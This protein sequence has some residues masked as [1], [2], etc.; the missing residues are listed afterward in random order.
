[1]R[2][3]FDAVPLGVFRASRSG[4]LLA[5]NQALADLL[6]YP[7]VA[8]LLQVPV[9]DLYTDTEARE[10]L[11]ARLDRP[12]ASARLET[13]FR[14]RDGSALWAE[15]WARCI[16]TDPEPVYAGVLSDTT[17]R[18]HM[19]DALRESEALFRRVFEQLPVG[20]ALV[21]MSGHFDRANA[22]WIK[23]IGYSETELRE[24]TFLD[25]THPDDK[26][27]SSAAVRRLYDGE[28]D[29]IEMEKRYVRKDGEIVWGYVS[30]RPIRDAAGQPLWTM[31]VII[32]ITG[33]RALEEQFR[34]AQKMEAIGRLAGGVAHDFNN[35]LT[36]I[37]GYSELL[38]EQIGPDKPM[39]RDL[40]QIYQGALRAAALTR[41][42]LAFSRKQ[43]LRPESV[44]LNQILSRFQ[45]LARP[46]LGEDVQLQLELDPSVGSICADVTQLEQV[47]MN[48]LVNS[49]DAMPSGG[50]IIIRTARY[51]VST[52]PPAR[53]GPMKPGEYVELSVQD[54]G[55]GM[56]EDTKRHV[57]E[58]FFTTKE[59]GKGTGLGL[60]TV[61]G[62]IEQM[63]GYI[64]VE[65]A[66]GRGTTFRICFPPS[67]PATRVA[68][69]PAVA[70][71]PV[72]SE[73]ILVVEDDPDARLFTTAALRRYGYRVTEAASADEALRQLEGQERWPD[74]VLTDIV[75]PGRNG[76]DLAAALLAERPGTR[77]LLTTGYLDN[78]VN[79]PA[80]D[81]IPILEKPF[82]ATTL[83]RRVRE[84]LERA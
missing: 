36:A 77:I 74:L 55:I 44:E 52:R 27:A 79:A 47:L 45:G 3:I 62:I 70:G 5:A 12:G 73:R 23:M 8:T 34:H 30:V 83:L 1:M 53:Q 75:M 26:A 2:E 28:T 20:T 81:T 51:V 43:V 6:G 14:R 11:L 58:P 56:D 19:E 71:L 18:R 15:V 42:L 33:R 7:D 4:R 66:P 76:R 22:A 35:I 64:W 9:G 50:R 59:P 61:Y 60:A 17:D 54:T 57:F 72:G 48:L 24:L 10:R 38:R 80:F 32:D 65:T 63:K 78:C 16:D 29:H 40:E 21:N 49:R 82:T 68:D 67:A 13:T 84:R 25:V 37:I 46:M 69:R 31:P 39:G 41:Q